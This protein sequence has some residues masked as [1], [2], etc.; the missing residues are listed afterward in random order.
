MQRSGGIVKGGNDTASGRGG[1]D[2]ISG[3]A[4]TFNGGTLRGGADSLYGG[5]DSD[6]IAGDIFQTDQTRAIGQ[7][8]PTPI[9]VVL[10]GG[11]DRIHGNN[12]NDV[13]AGDMLDAT[14]ADGS[15]I[16]GGDDM[17]F[18]D[19]GDDTIFGDCR[20]NNFTNSS[21]SD[22]NDRIDGGNGDDVVYG[23]GGNDTAAFDSVAAAVVVDLFSGVATGQ[24]DD[25]LFS[26]EN[27]IGSA[28]GDTLR[29]SGDANRLDGRAG[30]DYLAGRSGEDF[31]IGGDGKDKLDGGAGA[32]VLLGG[33]GNDQ[34]IFV[35]ATGAVTNERINDFENQAD[36]LD[37]TSFHFANFAAV[38][39]LADA[40]GAGI[41]IDL[42]GA[43]VLFITGLTL[44]TFGAGDVIL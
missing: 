5:E 10:T 4:F 32:D 15:T 41:K 3:D 25:Q 7:V 37:L 39:A 8:G 21:I 22:G 30:D 27:V 19:D 1:Q 11:G 33:A 16:A 6:L 2:Q 9:L 24:G 34:F 23:Q 29:G 31:L 38:Q 13:I 18:G 42:P 17:L 35:R 12:G 44:A 28:L 20:I 14:V 36:R 43:Q 40:S 26:I